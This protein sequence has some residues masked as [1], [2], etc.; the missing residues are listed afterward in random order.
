MDAQEVKVP[1]SLILR[2]S[3]CYS[4]MLID[5]DEPRKSK[6]KIFPWK[7]RAWT[8]VAGC[9]QNNIWRWAE[10]IEVVPES[11]YTG[12]AHRKGERGYTGARF[13][14]AGQVWVITDNKVKLAPNDEKPET[15]N[16][17]SL[18]A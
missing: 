10:I 16:Q 18:F 13:R 11:L 2:A 3:D 6:G 17:L 8:C 4:A 1:L 5:T 15:A 9:S 12:R 14:C 7:G